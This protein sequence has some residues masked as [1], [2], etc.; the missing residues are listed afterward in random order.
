MF[1]VYRTNFLKLKFWK[2]LSNPDVNPENGV[3][4]KKACSYNIL[5]YFGE[6]NS[7]SRF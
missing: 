7:T 2:L 3:A 4:Y 1:L 5:V 6:K